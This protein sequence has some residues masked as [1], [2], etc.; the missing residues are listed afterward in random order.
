ETVLPMLADWRGLLR[1]Y[2]EAAAKETLRYPDN[3]QVDA[4][5]VDDWLDGLHADGGERVWTAL[6]PHRL[7]SNAKKPV[8]RGDKLVEAWVRTLVASACGLPLRGFIVGRDAV[9][10]VEPLAPDDAAMAL[11]MLLQGF[12]DGM[13]EPL[14]VACKTALAWQE[15]VFQL[16]AAGVNPGRDALREV[17]GVYD[18]GY[19]LRGEIDEPCLARCYADFDA[20]TADG[21]FEELAER[22]YGPMQMWLQEHVSVRLHADAN[23]NANADGA[24][25]E[26]GAGDE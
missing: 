4:P 11:D 14:P 2:P 6:V 26:E 19:N 1:S 8:L 12:R 13:N 16:N 24:A 10:S 25:K 7:C 5:I 3:T 20:L 15:K 22:L 23:A 17:A 21:R 18:G 9:V